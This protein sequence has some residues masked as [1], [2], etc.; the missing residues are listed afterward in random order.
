MMNR[1]PLALAAAVALVTACDPATGPEDF[2]DGQVEVPEPPAEGEGLQFVQSAF[3][4]PPGK[5]V[6][7]CWV[8]DWVP[9]EDV[10]IKQFIGLQSGMGHHMVAL[11]SLTPQTPGTSYDCTEL[12]SM[13]GLNPLLV[14][15]NSPGSTEPEEGLR[16]FPDDFMVRVPAG[17]NIVIQSH[18]VNISDQPLRVADVARFEFVTA[19]EQDAFTE[20]S[21]FT[22][23]DGFI[24]VPVGESNHT[25]G[26]TCEI[27]QR[28][29]MTSL[30]G[31][32]HDWGTSVLI[33]R[34]RGGV[35]ETLYDVPEWTVEFRD[36][37][38][39]NKYLPSDPLVFEVGDKVHI[40]CTYDNTTDHALKFPEEMCVVF[41]SYFPATAEG[42][43]VCD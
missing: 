4:V 11:T 27:D 24:N 31:H 33:E 9:S 42:F 26:V 12:E 14:P 37:A 16:L 20:A 7:H 5:E 15:A 43:I 29:T 17:S 41:G 38:P 40:T 3:D 39:V 25:S 1:I 8:P 35:R 19:A 23:N 2:L 32:M 21:Y 6:Q 10:F 28:I 22:V 34:E 30:L 18:Y 36:L 13:V